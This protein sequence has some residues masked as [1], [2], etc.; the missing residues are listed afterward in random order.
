MRQTE[1]S[2]LDSGFEITISRPLFPFEKE[3]YRG[4]VQ[5]TPF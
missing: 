5:V 3:V 4:C 2:I 1:Y